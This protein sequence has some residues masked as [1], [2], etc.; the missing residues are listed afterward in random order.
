MP[1]Q[2]KQQISTVQLDGEMLP[3]TIWQQCSG[4]F[5]MNVY[6]ILE[7]SPNGMHHARVRLCIGQLGSL[8][9]TRYRR[10][11]QS[12]LLWI[13]PDRPCTQG[14]CV[15]WMKLVNSRFVS[16][17]TPHLPSVVTAQLLPFLELV[18]GS[19]CLVVLI[20]IISSI[21]VQCHAKTVQIV[22]GIN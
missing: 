8:L 17:S 9:N 19:G 16:H 11:H 3:E 18:S 12:P 6:C 21:R 7:I 10:I 22:R 20:W 5:N 4:I 2:N 1:S 15:V 13:L 14:S